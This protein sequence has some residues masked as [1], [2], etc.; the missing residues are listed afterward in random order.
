MATLNSYP[1]SILNHDGSATISNMTL[2][3]WNLSLDEYNT[4][5]DKY[6]AFSTHD[7][8]DTSSLT[9]AYTDFGKFILDTFNI[10]RIPFPTILNDTF[11]SNSDFS[12]HKYLEK[13]LSNYKSSYFNTSFFDL[14]KK[15]INRIPDSGYFDYCDIII[16]NG[17]GDTLE[18]NAFSFFKDSYLSDINR[19]YDW[20]SSLLSNIYIR[21]G[22]GGSSDNAWFI[23]SGITLIINNTK[24]YRLGIFNGYVGYTPSANSLNESLPTYNKISQTLNGSSLAEKTISHIIQ[25]TPTT[26][27][28]TD[29]DP[30]TPGGSSGGNTGGSGTGGGDGSSSSGGG[31][32]S[33]SG[34]SENAPDPSTRD[35]TSEG[36]ASVVQTGLISLYSPTQAQLNDLASYLWSEAFSIDSFKK[37]F[38]DPMDAILGLSIVPV[39]PSIA[40]VRNVTIGN[41]NTD[42]LMRIVSSQYVQFDCGNIKLD[43]YWGAFLDYAPYTK[44]N[45]YLPY[46]GVR[47]LSTDDVMKKTINV[48]YNIDLLSGACVCFI[49]CDDQVLY[50]FTGS[51]STQIP[52]TSVSYNNLYKACVDVLSSM[53]FGVAMGTSGG[54]DSLLPAVQ[55]QTASATEEYIIPYAESYMSD[56]ASVRAMM[57]MKPQV[58]RSGA[59]TSSAGQLAIQT[60]YLIVE[61]PRQCVPKKQNSYTGY[62]SYQTKQVSS[63]SGY[64]TWATVH[65]DNLT[66]TADEKNEIGMIM[67]NG[68]IL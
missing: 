34:D 47:Q 9:F 11:S 41:V 50:Q 35:D 5:R 42:I 29:T 48:K 28:P 62:P 43:E 15:Y 66:A 1:Y 30:F 68:V 4:I 17:L 60:P 51:V 7:F 64:T 12:L 31:G 46:I 52:V 57:S 56:S 65:L 33:F 26:V 24:I 32:G 45:I 61:R 53:Y 55:G 49:K 44:V 67:K 22:T 54:T 13:G 20:F 2:Y 40:S 14:F 59:V 38:A 58:S 10:N 63:Q 23:S 3:V 8:F 25:A 6:N 21:S 39:E 27:D 16:Q 37:I 18:K 19:N 36:S